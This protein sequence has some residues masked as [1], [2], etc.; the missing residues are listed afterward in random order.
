MTTLVTDPTQRAISLV[1]QLPPDQLEVALDFLEQLAQNT[2]FQETQLLQKI[3]QPFDSQLHHRLSQ[4]IGQRDA[5][6]LTPQEGQELVQLTQQ[7]EALNV[8]R[9]N[10]LAA[11]AKLRQ[12]TLPKLIKDLGLK[13]IEYA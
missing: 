3:R 5:E 6:Q 4:L 7:V 12:T 10:Y 13:P 1:E 8:D 9:I 2:Q 11:L